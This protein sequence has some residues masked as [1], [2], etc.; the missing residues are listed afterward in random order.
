[1]QITTIGPDLAKN[2]FKVTGVNDPGLTGRDLILAIG[3]DGLE[4]A[5]AV[6]GYLK[7]CAIVYE[8]VASSTYSRRMH[9]SSGIV[10]G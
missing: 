7:R 4:H 9:E 3:I 10:F 8:R 2:M 5:Q 1:M 6:R